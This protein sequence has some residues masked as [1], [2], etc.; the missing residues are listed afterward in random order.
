MNSLK[1]GN[2]AFIDGNNIFKGIKSLGWC[3]DYTKFRVF[4]KDKYNVVKAYYFIGK[5]QGNERLYQYLSSNGYDLIFKPTVRDH[6]G[7]IKGNCDAELV[8]QVMIDKDKYKKA[9]IVTG[10][11]DFACLVK[12]LQNEKKFEFLL[13]PVIADCSVLLRRALP[14]QIDFLETL[15]QRLERK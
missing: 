8:L 13:A 6:Q 10:D 5:I 4:L 12:H 9:V 7:L 14:N 3:L 15:K 1:I 11:G 2:Y